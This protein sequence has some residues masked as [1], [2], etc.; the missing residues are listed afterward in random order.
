MIKYY[1]NEKLFKKL[2]VSIFN[3][4]KNHTR[5][6]LEGVPLCLP[7]QGVVTVTSFLGVLLGVLKGG[8]P[9]VYPLRGVVTVTSFLCDEIL[10]K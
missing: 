6:I 2:N 5:G 3:N 7:P 8:Y 9:P 1:P 4:T 10:Y